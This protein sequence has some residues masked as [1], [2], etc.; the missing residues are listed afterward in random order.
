MVAGAVGV[1]TVGAGTVGAGPV[2]AGSL[3]ERATGAGAGGRFSYAAEE[4]MRNQYTRTG[5]RPWFPGTQQ[6]IR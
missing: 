5:H 6:Y 1:G 2:G 3:G 4:G